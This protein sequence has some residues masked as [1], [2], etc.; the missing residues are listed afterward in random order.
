MQPLRIVDD[1]PFYQLR[2]AG[3]R[4]I[5]RDFDQPLQRGP[6]YRFVFEL[7]NRATRAQELFGPGRRDCQPFI[8]GSE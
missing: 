4:G 7:P 6:I 8:D 5:A 1:Q 2:V 3:R